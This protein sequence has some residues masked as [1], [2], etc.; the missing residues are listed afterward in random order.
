LYRGLNNPEA[1]VPKTDDIDAL[2]EAS[3]PPI[4]VQIND[5]IYVIQPDAAQ[6][7]NNTTNVNTNNNNNTNN[8]ST[9]LTNTSNLS[10]Q[11]AN[12]SKQPSE[13]PI[14]TSP[15]TIDVLNYE[16]I[17]DQEEYELFHPFQMT[18]GRYRVIAYNRTG[19]K[20]SNFSDSLS[21]RTEFVCSDL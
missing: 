6:T 13:N 10:S 5:V 21:D 7:I 12:N 11:T 4:A 15:L 14:P 16:D 1:T 2:D 20:I 8:I 18:D 3:S 19:K 9:N 17:I